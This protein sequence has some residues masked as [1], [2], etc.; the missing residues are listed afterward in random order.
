MRIFYLVAS[1]IIVLFIF[2]GGLDLSSYKQ[3][4]LEADRNI[5]RQEYYGSELGKIYKNRFGLAYLNKIYPVGTKI[6]SVFFSSID[7]AA[8][9]F[10]LFSFLIFIG[11][12]KHS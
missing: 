7:S 6:E 1:I 10:S 9:Y 2:G 12:K 3:S 4:T 11:Y 8:F 5:T